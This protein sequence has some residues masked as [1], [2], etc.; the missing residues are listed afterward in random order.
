MASETFDLEPDR[1]RGGERARDE[2]RRARRRAE[3]PRAS[4]FTRLDDVSRRMDGWW[5]EWTAQAPA[6]RRP[7]AG[8]SLPTLG[9]LLA[10]EAL[11][12]VRRR[13]QPATPP[14]GHAELIGAESEIAAAHELYTRSSWLDDPPAFHAAPPP[15]EVHERPLTWSLGAA[16][17]LCFPSDYSPALED[18]GR[19]RWLAQKANRQ[20]HA[21]LARADGDASR[22]LVCVPGLGVGGPLAALTSFDAIGL[23]RRHDLNVLVY[24]PPM[25]GPRRTTRRRGEGAFG[26]FP[27][28]YVHFVSQAVWDLRRIL[29]WIR[30]QGGTRVGTFGLAE[31]SASTALLANLEPEL[32]CVIAGLPAI[33]PLR[34]AETYCRSVSEYTGEEAEAV[35]RRIEAVYRVVSPFASAPQVPPGRRA[36]FAGLLDRIVPAEDVERLWSHWGHPELVWYPGGHVSYG[37]EAEVRNLITRTLWNAHLIDPDRRTRRAARPSW[38]MPWRPSERGLR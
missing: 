31:G 13:V 15:A 38:R 3:S 2:G 28:S 27:L 24:V 26:P 14:L 21:W 37:G 32:A 16:S 20:G 4:V 11:L 19:A 18:P 5:S 25:H 1:S 8:P 6:P 10:D 12:R 34:H 36:L 17:E 9:K 23:R 35:A 7:T 33:D 29:G 30:S 22:W